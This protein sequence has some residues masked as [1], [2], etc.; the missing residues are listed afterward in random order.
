[1]IRTCQKEMS[2]EEQSKL[3]SFRRTVIISKLQKFRQN[4][5]AILA[6]ACRAAAGCWECNIA[7]DSSGNLDTASQ[8]EAFSRFTA[9]NRITDKDGSAQLHQTNPVH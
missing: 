6:G 4:V 3:C 9:K 7:N 1:M 8:M 2:D 5:V